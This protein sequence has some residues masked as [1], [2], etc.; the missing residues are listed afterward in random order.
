MN[1]SSNLSII[2]VRILPPCRDNIRKCLKENV[3]YYLNTN[4]DISEDG[5]TIRQ[6]EKYL[7]AI[8]DNFFNQ[9]EIFYDDKLNSYSNRKEKKTTPNISVSAIVGKNGD[10]KSSLS[11]SL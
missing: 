1:T 2:A 3:F 7:E 4:F 5:Y 10:G 9:E 11:S 8:N 6:R